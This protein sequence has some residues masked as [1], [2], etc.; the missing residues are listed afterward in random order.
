MV[1]KGKG[2]GGERRR[3]EERGEKSRGQQQE[4]RE[5]PALLDRGR[6]DGV[7]AGAGGLRSAS[8]ERVSSVPPSSRLA[9]PLAA[10]HRSKHIKIQRGEGRGERGREE[11]RH[12]AITF[13]SGAASPLPPPSSY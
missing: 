9:S 12:A 11:V 13:H 10:S 1:A 2:W 7:R 5:E 6:V 4:P 3:G 8:E